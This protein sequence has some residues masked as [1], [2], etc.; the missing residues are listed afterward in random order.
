[1]QNPF[2]G[3]LVCADAKM[4]SQKVQKTEKNMKTKLC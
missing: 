2:M 1:M 4:K 3:P